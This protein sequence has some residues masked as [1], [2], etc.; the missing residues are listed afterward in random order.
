MIVNP[1]PSEIDAEA[2]VLLAGTAAGVLPRILP[3]ASG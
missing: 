2:H 1:H 3:G